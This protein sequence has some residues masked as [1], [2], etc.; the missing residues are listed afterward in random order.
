MLALFA[1][2]IYDYPYIIFIVKQQWCGS[3]NCGLTRDWVV[4]RAQSGQCTAVPTSIAVI[5]LGDKVMRAWCAIVGMEQL[6]WEPLE[7]KIQKST[8][9]G[10]AALR[11]RGRNLFFDTSSSPEGKCES[12]KLL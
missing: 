7:D 10:F 1:N 2:L 5:I 11:Y 9:L 4:R 12:R 6:G 8:P 3:I